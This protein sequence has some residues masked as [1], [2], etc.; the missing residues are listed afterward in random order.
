MKKLISL[1]LA[2]AMIMMVG[3]V[4]AD[5]PASALPKA[6]I[7]ITNM[8]KDDEVSLYKIIKWDTATADWAF[9]GITVSGYET[10][11]ELLTALNGDQASAAMTALAHIFS[12]ISISCNV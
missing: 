5:E 6:N 1:V 9:N 4:Y 11:T 10:V 12:Q 2:L 7:S 8:G 3:A